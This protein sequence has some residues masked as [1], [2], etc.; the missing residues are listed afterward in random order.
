MCLRFIGHILHSL[1]HKNI[2]C[3]SFGKLKEKDFEALKLCT[4]DSLGLYTNLAMTPLT[5]CN[6]L[7]PSFLIHNI[8]IDIYPALCSFHMYMYNISPP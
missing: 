8:I 6:Y 4:F 1:R 2:Y 3:W 7:D 5:P